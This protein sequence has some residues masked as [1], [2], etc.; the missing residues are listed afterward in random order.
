MRFRPTLWPTLVTVPMFAVL[1]GLGFWQ[2]ERLDWKTAHIEE[3]R[4]RAAGTPIAL[5]RDGRIAV[6]DFLYRPARVTGHYLNTAD[7]YLR[8]QVRDGRPGV[9]IV[10]PLV[11]ED[12]GSVV[13]VD[14]GWAPYDWPD[15]GSRAIAAEPIAVTVT[16]IIRP[17][18]PPRWLVPDNRPTENQWYFVDPAA[19]AAHAGLE[20]DALP[21]TGYYLFATE[22]APVVLSPETAEDRPAWPVANVWRVDLPNNHL[23]YAITWFALAL[24]L[25]AIYLIYHTQREHRT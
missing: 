17:A 24:A 23:G 4:V 12:D 22:E 1:I 2:L 18:E 14:R 8:N 19:M 9:H 7:M 16:G 15:T 5:P 11:R 3:R 21:V 20:S 25:L 13:M 10:T 6:D